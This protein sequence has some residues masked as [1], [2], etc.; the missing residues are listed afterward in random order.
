MFAIGK[1]FRLADEIASSGQADDDQVE[2]LRE[3]RL[4]MRVAI[5]S[6]G[7]VTPSFEEDADVFLESVNKMNQLMAGAP[8][9]R[10]TIKEEERKLQRTYGS[11]LEKL[12]QESIN[13]THKDF[14]EVYKQHESL[15]P[16]VGPL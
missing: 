16:A 1:Y 7:V 11:L 2:Q 9:T 15:N 14:A 8:R 10:E 13:A 3:L 6:A 5:Y 4:D 12:R